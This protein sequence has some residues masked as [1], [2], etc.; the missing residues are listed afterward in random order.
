MVRL[1]EIEAR[2]DIDAKT[3]QAIS[4]SLNDSLRAMAADAGLKA[5]VGAL[6]PAIPAAGCVLA[7]CDPRL[8]QL[9]LAAFDQARIAEAKVARWRSPLAAVHAALE[10]RGHVGEQVPE[11][12]APPAPA[13]GPIDG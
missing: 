7:S 5:E 4:R 6:S 11:G 3:L 1:Y 2:E 13:S 9:A 8:Q 10:A 12:S